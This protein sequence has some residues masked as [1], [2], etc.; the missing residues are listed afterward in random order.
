MIELAASWLLVLL[1]SGT[2]L[3]WP[4]LRAFAS[5]PTSLRRWHWL[6]GL[7]LGLLS[8][9]I[10][11]TGLT[12]SQHAGERIKALRDAT[13]QA[14]P[15]APSGLKSAGT[16]TL[17][18]QQALEVTRKAHADLGL[19][20]MPILLTPPNDAR[21]VWRA[22][23]VDRSRPNS[24]SSWVIDASSGSVLFQ[25]DWAQQTVFSKATAI[26]IPFHRGEFGLW[27]QLLLAIFG[28]G[29]LASIATGW[30][31]MAQRVKK[32]AASG[33]NMR[34]W[35]AACLPRA[36]PIRFGCIPFWVWP[37]VALMLL[38]M[39]VLCWSVV[40]V[41]LADAW[42]RSQSQPGGRLV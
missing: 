34:R 3:A 32:G 12:W 40:P 35:V 26:G 1:I 37:L 14:P 2:L 22:N 29:L 17:T 33:N 8:L 13:N 18:W 39:P 30:A 23:A 15:R 5:H 16:Q 9:I 21:G 10:V 41:V 7:S 11:L 38:G 36:L 42:L 25:S 31:M 19:P 27:N 4:M 28:I 6:G 20:A 24:Q